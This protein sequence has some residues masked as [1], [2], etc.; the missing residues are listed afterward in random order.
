[1][2]STASLWPITMRWGVVQQDTPRDYLTISVPHGLSTKNSHR[3]STCRRR[4]L[5]DRPPSCM[6][7]PVGSTPCMRHLAQYGATSPACTSCCASM[8][9]VSFSAMRPPK[10]WRIPAV[11]L[12]TTPGFMTNDA[13]GSNNVRAVSK[14]CASMA[15]TSCVM[16]SHRS[17]VFIAALFIEP[18]GTLH[19]SNE[20][21]L[22]LLMAAKDRV[23]GL[24]LVAFTSRGLAHP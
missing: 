8:V 18:S 12:T 4:M 5:E 3:P 21:A 6:A 10:P 7:V 23:E 1:M 13:P 20:L 22:N 24:R 16:R 17:G 15:V 14:S 11:P 2:S 9:S 19:L